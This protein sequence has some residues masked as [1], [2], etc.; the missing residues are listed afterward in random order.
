MLNT[1]AHNPFN[2]R[3]LS[4]VWPSARPILNQLRR[5]GYIFAFTLPWP[6]PII[7][8]HVGDFWMF[9][10]LNAFGE[11][12][13]PTQPLSGVQGWDTLAGSLGP[14]FDELNTE[15]SPDGRSV[16]PLDPDEALKY[17]IS[18]TSRVSTGGWFE[19]LKLYRDGLA[20]NRWNKSLQCVWDLNQIEQVHNSVTSSKSPDAPAASGSTQ[21]RR[22]SSVSRSVG[23]LDSGP[24]GS[25]G[26][27][28]TVIWGA[29][30]IALNTTLSTE[31]IS[32]YFG[33]RDSHLVVLPHLGH[34]TQLDKVG[35]S[36]WQAV[37]IWAVEGE[38]GSLGDSLAEYPAAKI[39]VTS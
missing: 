18:V 34:W 37:I 26:A 14:G 15:L 11:S 32:D 9:R 21:T 38:H 27:A 30:D 10:L 3:P 20:T 17:P 35:A 22:S 25:L 31:G 13:N 33:M 7:L 1:W 5:S 19:K 23:V 24:R 2:W 6:L 12:T 29:K 8:G 4:K 39:L 36:V 16:D 28:T